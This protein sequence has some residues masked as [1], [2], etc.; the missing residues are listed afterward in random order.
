MLRPRRKSRRLRP[1]P[2][3]TRRLGLSS[4]TR[5]KRWRKD[6]VI[7]VPGGSDLRRLDVEVTEGMKF[8]NGYVSPEAPR[9]RERVKTCSRRSRR[10]IPLRCK[11]ESL[12][13]G[14]PP[15]ARAARRDRQTRS[16]D[17]RRGRRRRRAQES[18]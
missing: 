12:A 11:K 5:W 16:R 6:G 13:Q 7:T 2:R 1:S 14:H 18:F 3:R 10:S 17:H 4:P 9:T 15:R 8:D